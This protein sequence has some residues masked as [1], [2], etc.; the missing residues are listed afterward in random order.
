[1]GNHGIWKFV[2]GGGEGGGGGRGGGRGGGGGGQRNWIID[3]CFYT[4]SDSSCLTFSV[5]SALG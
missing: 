4:V 1:M 5:V 2:G 3:N